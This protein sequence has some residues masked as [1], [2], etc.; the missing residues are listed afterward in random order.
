[1]SMK[2]EEKTCRQRF[3]DLNGLMAYTTLKRNSALRL[4]REAKARRVYGRRILFDLNR[5][6]S[7]F[8]NQAD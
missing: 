4:G 6:D 8:D 7:F 1:M 3:V 5:I 2:D